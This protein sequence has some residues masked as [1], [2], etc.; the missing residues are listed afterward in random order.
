MWRN[1]FNISTQKA[2]EDKS[3]NSRSVFLKNNFQVCQRYITRSP[4][5]DNNK[6]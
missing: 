5:R 6:N 1:I 2:G 4:Q 3:V